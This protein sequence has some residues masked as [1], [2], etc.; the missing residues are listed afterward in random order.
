MQLFSSF[1]PHI[2]FQ[3]S[4][5]LSFYDFSL[6]LS[7]SALLRKGLSTKSAV[8]PEIKMMGKRELVYTVSHQFHD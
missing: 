8:V 5:S 1:P 3:S 7:N 4:E 6:I 2:R